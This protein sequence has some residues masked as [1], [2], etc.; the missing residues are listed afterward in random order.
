MK[1]R[2]ALLCIAKDED[3]YIKEWV[4]YHL[5]LG[6][7]Q[8]FV[9]CDN[10]ACPLRSSGHVSVINF[11]AMIR[12]PQMPIYNDMLDV[13]R[14]KFDWVA[15]FDCDE[16]LVLKRHDTVQEFLSGRSESVGINWVLFGDNGLTEDDGSH[17]VIDRFTR[18]Q[19]I[20]NKH[21]KCIV[22]CDPD[23]KMATPH[24]PNK[25]WRGSDGELHDYAFCENGC[26][27][28]AQINH[29]FCKTL[30]EWKKKQDRGGPDGFYR[31]PDSDFDRHNFNEVEDLSAKIWKT[32]NLSVDL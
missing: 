19:S 1:E 20:P 2:V 6:F 9:C 24:S 11:P 4:D 15:F 29:Y 25:L 28:E 13:L 12:P 14:G 23:V 30:P 7:D 16:F 32:K 22:K 21:V 10:W 18:R 8:I 26:I 27:D 3:R 17:G 31:R 5:S